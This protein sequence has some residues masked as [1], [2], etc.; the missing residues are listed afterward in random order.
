MRIQNRYIKLFEFSLMI[1]CGCLAMNSILSLTIIKEAGFFPGSPLILTGF[2]SLVS[3]YIY[4]NTGYIKVFWINIMM[5]IPGALS[6]S[7]IKWN[8]ERY[9]F[10]MRGSNLWIPPYSYQKKLI[11]HYARLSFEF[12]NT[13]LS[14]PQVLLTGLILMFGYI[15]LI[16]I[17]KIKATQLGLESRGEAPENT[18]K[19]SNQQFKLF[20]TLGAVSLGVAIGLAY[21]TD[22]AILVIGTNTSG[23]ESFYILLSFIA[24]L[25]IVSGSM[26]YIRTSVQ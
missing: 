24:I 19:I 21:L 7:V 13:T 14:Y 9:Y 5:Y 23:P 8:I 22:I 2:W 12:F 1:L 16:I 6:K 25:V 3:L 18:L 26:A 10:T 20:L 15:T 17:S 4:V 11:P